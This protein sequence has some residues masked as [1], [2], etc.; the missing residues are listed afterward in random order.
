MNLRL[1]YTLLADGS[2]DRTLLPLLNW[3]LEQVHP[4][5]HIQPQFAS[6]VPST[7]MSLVQRVHLAMR[8]YPCDVLFIHRD[9][10]RETLAARVERNPHPGRSHRAHLHTCRTCSHDRSLAAVQ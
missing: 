5:I 10:E 4:D 7:G 2:S 3:L 8:L 6:R 1:R 9:A